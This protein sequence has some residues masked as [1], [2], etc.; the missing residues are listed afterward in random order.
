MVQTLRCMTDSRWRGFVTGTVVTATVQSSA[1]VSVL[2]AELVQSGL[3]TL[4]RA[5]P[6]LIGANVGTTVTAWLLC[7]AQGLPDTVTL[8]AVLAIVGTVLYLTPRRRHWGCVLLGL[9][10]LLSGMDGITAAARPLMQTDW[11]RR[12]FTTVQNPLLGLSMGMLLTVLVQSSSASVG[13]LQALSATGQVRCATA[14]P[15]LLGQ[16]IGTCLTVFFVALGGKQRAGQ[17][18]WAHLLFN[19]IGSTV[20]LLLQ[21]AIRLSHFSYLLTQPVNSMSVAMLHT[22]FNLISAAIVLPCADGF[23]RLVEEITAHPW[24]VSANR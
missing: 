1:A 23:A 3:L 5:I 9:F 22:L 10:L 11:L 19:V 16:N 6:V 24:N 15:I 21:G 12:L 14:L 18:A 7:L 8:S 13:L 17:V 2:T 4:R 20:M